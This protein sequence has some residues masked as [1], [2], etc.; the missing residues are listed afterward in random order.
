MR[1]EE[2]RA[3]AKMKRKGKERVT[4]KRK[5]NAEIEKMGYM[6]FDKKGRN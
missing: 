5:R 6:R 2:Q 1:K 4:N 3:R